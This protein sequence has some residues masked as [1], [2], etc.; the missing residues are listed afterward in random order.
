MTSRA[1]TLRR[2][3][4]EEF[5]KPYVYGVSDCHILG[6]RVADALAGTELVKLST[7]KY[8][9]LAGAQVALKKAGYTSMTNF[10]EKHLERIP[11]ATATIGDI[12]VIGGNNPRE[13]HVGV[14]LGPRFVSR[15]ERGRT[16]HEL[17]ECVSA[18]RTRSA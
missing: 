17:D 16:M 4:D 8:D 10:W 15:N 13:H 2:V 7:G 9:S 11:P 12:V 14:C 1:A 6:C 5:A 3:I 18:F